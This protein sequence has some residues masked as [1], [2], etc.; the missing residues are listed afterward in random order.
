MIDFSQNIILEND[1]VRLQPLKWNDYDTLL[2]FAVNEPEL[3]T[4]SLVSGAGEEG[5]K[6]Y[7]DLALKDR[8]DNKSYPFLVIDKR[9]NQV[10]GS[11]RFY[12]YQPNHSTI[13]LGFTWYGKKFQGTGLNK[14][15][16]FLMLQKAFEDWKIQRVEFRA[17]ATNQK[18]IHAMKSIGCIEEGILRSNCASPSGRRDS[19]ILSILPTEWNIRVKEHLSSQIK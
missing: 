12:D 9:T 13:Q 5:L 7:M 6:N 16:K 8:L 4:Y 3:W 11:T 19:I 2:V 18:S 10:A 14:N 15:C 17:D 1:V